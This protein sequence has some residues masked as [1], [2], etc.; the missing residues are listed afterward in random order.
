MGPGCTHDVLSEE[1]DQDISASFD[2][3]L[4][5]FGAG[6]AAEY[7]LSLDACFLRLIDNSDLGRKRN[8]IRAGLRSAAVASHVV[9]YRIDA[10]SLRVVRVL[11]GSRDLP[12]QFP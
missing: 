6:Q 8:E 2:Y 10:N 11:N 1:T 3:S 4:K 7:L 9:F 12:R 5:T